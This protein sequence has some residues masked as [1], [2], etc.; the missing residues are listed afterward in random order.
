MKVKTVNTTWWSSP[1]KQEGCGF[2]TGLS[3]CVFLYLQ[4]DTDYPN[5]YS[6]SKVKTFGSE[7]ILAGPHQFK[8]LIER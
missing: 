1:L 5:M 8:G 4:Q 2:K 6:A 3:L 7:D